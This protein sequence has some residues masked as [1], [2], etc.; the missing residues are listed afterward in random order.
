MD[1]KLQKLSDGELL[2]KAGKGNRQAFH[3]LY[4]KYSALVLACCLGVTK[5]TH[6]AEDLVTRIF[7][8]VLSKHH[9]YN[10][11][12]GSFRNWLWRVAQ[13]VAINYVRH[14]SRRHDLIVTTFRKGLLKSFLLL[15][16]LNS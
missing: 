6:D 14:E 12:Y 13:R 3:V 9:Y 8:R 4:S 11:Q 7:Y 2:R 10:P 1:S 5:N 15:M 16:L